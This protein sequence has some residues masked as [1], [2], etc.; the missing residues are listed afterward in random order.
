MKEGVTLSKFVA[1]DV[2]RDIEVVSAARLHEGFI[3]ARVRTTNLLYVARKLAAQP[4]FELGSEV[5]G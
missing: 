1:P 2:R 4:D 3:T 5:S